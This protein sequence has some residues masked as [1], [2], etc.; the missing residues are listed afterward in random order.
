LGTEKTMQKPDN[1]NHPIHYKEGGIEAIEILR[2]KLTPEEFRGF[3]KGNALKY[4]LR[5]NFK[6]KHDEDLQKAQWYLSYYNEL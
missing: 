2:A 5:A 6:N 1:V 3:C 4:L